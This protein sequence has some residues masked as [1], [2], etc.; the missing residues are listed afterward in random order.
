MG[1]KHITFARCDFMEA[2]S[3]VFRNIYQSGDFYDV[4]LVP[5]D[6]APIRAHKLV[7]SGSSS[8]FQKLLTTSKDMVNVSLCHS[9]LSLIVQ[10]IYTGRCDVKLIDIT[11]FLISAK[12]LKIK[13][14]INETKNV[15][16]GVKDSSS[17]K[18]PISGLPQN[19]KMCNSPLIIKVLSVQ[20]DLERDGEPGVIC[21]TIDANEQQ[22]NSLDP[23]V[24]SG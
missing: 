22:T 15:P 12:H 7:L 24:Y 20:T 5:E 19:Y 2:S 9:D 10:F 13:G 6:G 3:L 8:V 21:N 23:E 4:T 16:S 14:L 17:S 18:H 1:D 11:S